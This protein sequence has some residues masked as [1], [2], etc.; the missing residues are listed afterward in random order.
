MINN[1]GINLTSGLLEIIQEGI[2]SYSG[3][4]E[5]NRT[6][7]EHVISNKGN[8][9]SVDQVEELVLINQSLQKCINE[10]ESILNKPVTRGF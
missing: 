4:I 9:L 2:K 3:I 7:I 1:N 10:A 6:L 5:D 8:E